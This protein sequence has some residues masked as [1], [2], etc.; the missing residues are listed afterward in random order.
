MSTS[1]PKTQIF[2]NTTLDVVVH[3]VV[4]YVEDFSTDDGFKLP[5][6]GNNGYNVNEVEATSADNLVKS[7]FERGEPEE[8]AIDLHTVY[9]IMSDEAFHY[10]CKI[11]PLTGSVTIL[12]KTRIE[13]PLSE[14]DILKKKIVEVFIISKPTQRVH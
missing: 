11:P 3:V 5:H 12:E 6:E 9:V 2:W 7:Y 14:F 8:I 10:F 4:R 13:D 1:V